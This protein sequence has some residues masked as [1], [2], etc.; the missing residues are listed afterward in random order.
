MPM[1]ETV[2]K[3]ILPH[4]IAAERA[5]IGSMILDPDAIAHVTGVITGDD[6][7]QHQYG[8]LFDTIVELYNSG[9]PVDVVTLQAQLKLK[10]VPEEF[11][12]LEFIG[13]LVSSVPTS[14]NVPQYAAQ[15]SETAQLRRLIKVN[16]DIANA[17]YLHKESLEEIMGQTEKKIFDVLQKMNSQMVPG[18][19]AA[20]PAK[21]EAVQAEKAAAPA[22]EKAA[23]AEK[24]PASGKKSASAPKTG[25]RGAKK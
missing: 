13:S 16:E 14:T 22:N 3:R 11:S 1:E 8:V 19:K 12:S 21:E 20:S 25:S 4:D 15:V 10:D 6:F 17:C 18:A 9:K 2:I 5:V 23:K 7:Y 24:N